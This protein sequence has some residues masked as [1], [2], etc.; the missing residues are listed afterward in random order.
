MNLTAADGAHGSAW[1]E[2]L[3]EQ[4]TEHAALALSLDATIVWANAAAARILGY[5]LDE[6]HGLHVSAIFTPEDKS[7]GIPHLEVDVAR[8]GSVSEDDRWQ[9][10]RDGARF[11]ASGALVPLYDKGGT[12]TGFGKVFRNRTDLRQQFDTLQNQLDAALTM[13]R[14]R[15]HY[16]ATIAHELRNPMTP[17]LMTSTLL[18]AASDDPRVHDAAA[19]IERQIAQ[20]TRVIDEVLETATATSGEIV[21]A[22]E[23]VSMNDVMAE[24]E[25]LLAPSSA[26]RGQSL[27]LLVPEVP[28]FVRGDRGRLVQVF[29]NLLANAIKFTPPRG[30]IWMKL[31]KEGAEIVAR[32]EDTG[33]GLAKDQMERIFDMFARADPAGEISGFG[34]GLAIV[35][36]FVEGHDGTVQAESDG[37]GMGCKFTVRLPM[38]LAPPGIEERP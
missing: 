37:V 24:V 21:L 23:P 35:K 4:D 22:R 20:M 13:A 3:L 27:S 18:R 17:L 25:A 34:I 9:Q 14:Q 28:L 1:P 31:T 16:I 10:T 19:I 15:D 26:Q 8:A 33:L 11:W 36:A 32:V 29:T 38:L 7:F 5:T 6:L 30:R 2:L 12:L